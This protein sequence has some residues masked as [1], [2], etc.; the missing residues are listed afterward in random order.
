MQYQGNMDIEQ[1]STVL[2]NVYSVVILGQLNS[3]LVHL[4]GET[5]NVLQLNTPNGDGR[6]CINKYPKHHSG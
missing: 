5:K 2:I 6:V 3:L 4:K 1:M